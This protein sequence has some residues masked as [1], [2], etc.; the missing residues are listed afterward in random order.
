[1]SGKGFTSRWRW[2]SKITQIILHPSKVKAAL[3]LF[4]EDNQDT[5]M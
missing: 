2:Q 3:A 5:W 1:M 4:M